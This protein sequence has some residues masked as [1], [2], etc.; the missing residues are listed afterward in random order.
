MKFINCE[1]K[2][3]FNTWFIVIVVVFSLCSTFLCDMF[4]GGSNE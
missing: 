2:G 3:N 4:Y 1:Q